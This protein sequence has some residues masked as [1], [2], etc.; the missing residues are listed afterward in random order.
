MRLIIEK[1]CIRNDMDLNSDQKELV[2]LFV[3]QEFLIGK[4]YKLFSFRY[5]A[6]K[7]FWTEM[8]TEEHLHASW[9]KRFI[10]RDPTD[11]FKFSQ[12]ELRLSGLASSI[13]S[14]EGLIAGVRNNSEFTITQA[15]SMALHLEKALWEQ[16]V[17]QCFEGDSVEVRKI[18]DS[19][20]MEQKRHITKMEKFSLGFIQNKPPKGTAVD[21]NAGVVP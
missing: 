3:R 19:L 13:E 4:L 10:A 21:K 12:G 18:L 8:A 16:K 11:K 14:I 1:D 20:N 17:F 6:F 5:P 15:V 2:E 9:L 7:D